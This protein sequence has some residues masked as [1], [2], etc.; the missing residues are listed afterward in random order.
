VKPKPS[1]SFQ[2][3]YT[4]ESDSTNKTIVRSL[5]ER[6]LP[7][8]YLLQAAFQTDGKGQG[9]ASWESEAGKNLLFSFVLR[10]KALEIQRQFYI[11]V[12]VS[13]ALQQTVRELLPD[14]E[15]R[16]KWPN[17]IYVGDQK[18]AGILIENAIRGRQFE[19]VLTGVGLNVN[20]TEFVSGAPNPVSLKML[21]GKNFDI[22]K[23][24][25]VFEKYFAAYY[26][27]L[28]VGQYEKLKSEYLKLMYRRG[29]WARFCDRDER[30]FEGRI[31]GIDSFGFLRIE[32]RAGMRTF[33]V[34]EVEYK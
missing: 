34:K 27:D 5:S 18:I 28:C 15:V 11:S 1:F 29:I 16:I 14:M 21:T 32:T 19:W 4:D 2:K 25:L 24:L 20:Q 23:I 26:A 33:D 10:P 31:D 13:L 30:I 7:E 6:H 22:N 17:D 8:G 9:Q 12:I 3:Q